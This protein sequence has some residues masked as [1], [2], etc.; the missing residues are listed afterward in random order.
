[1]KTPGKLLLIALLTCLALFK[2]ESLQAGNEK[3]ENV[4]GTPIQN[5]DLISVTD[6]KLAYMIANAGTWQ[7][8]FRNTEVKN[9]VSLYV[10]PACKDYYSNFT[11]SVTADITVYDASGNTKT[12][13]HSFS[14][15]FSASAGNTDTYTD[16]M[17]FEDGHKVEVK[18]TSVSTSLASMPECVK[19]K[20]EI[21]VDRHY[22]LNHTLSGAP[23][24][25][26]ALINS[27][28][29]IEFTWNYVLGAEEYELEWLFI[30]D[31][32][33]DGTYFSTSQL[34]YDFDRQATRVTVPSISYIIPNIYEHGY[35]AYR[36][37]AIGRHT[38]KREWR[39]EGAWWPGT[40]SG[41][42]NTYN[43][44]LQI[45]AAHEADN[46]N[47]SYSANYAEDGKRQEQ[48]N[49]MDG[50]MRNRQSVGRSQSISE[51]IVQETFYDHQGRPGVFTLPAPTGD[52]DL[53]Y[54]DD[55]NLNPSGTEYTAADFDNNDT[56][57]TTGC[58]IHVDGMSTASGAARYYSPNN[59]DK[60]GH[61]AFVPDADSVPFAQI[62]YTNDMSGRL[63]RQSGFGPDH[64]L[65]S[66][67][68]TKYLYGDPSQ[69]FL[70]RMF[71]TDVGLSKH[72]KEITV[73]DPNGQVSSSYLDQKGNI[74][75]TSLGGG[76]HPDMVPLANNPGAVNDT[77]S[78]LDLNEL[79]TNINNEPYI[80]MSRNLVVKAAG[81]Y[82]FVYA[83][84]TQ[85]F[86]DTCLPEGMCLEC[87]YDL[88][89]TIRD[90][91][92]NQMI[93]GG[94]IN[95][96]IGQYPFDVD[97]N[98][99]VRHN[100]GWSIYLN[101]GEYYVDKKLTIKRDIADD[102]VQAYIDSSSC[103]YDYDHFLQLAL[104]TIDFS[105]C[106]HTTSSLSC[107]DSLG[108]LDDFINDG[109]DTATYDSLFAECVGAYYGY[110]NPCDPLLDQ[111]ARDLS[112]G[113]QYALY[114][115]SL[116]A[117]NPIV[118]P[119]SILNENNNL[120]DGNANWRNPHTPYVDGSG[121]LDSIYYNGSYYP[122]G[123]DSISVDLFIANWKP[124]WAYSLVEYHPEY[125]YYDYCLLNAASHAWDNLFD[126]TANFNDALANGYLNP[127][128][129]ST[130]QGKPTSVPSNTTNQ[131]PFFDTGGMGAALYS[132]LQSKLQN[133]ATIGTETYTIW[134]MAQIGT[135]CPGISTSAQ[136][137]SCLL[138]SGNF[139]SDSCN[140][141]MLWALFRDGY[142]G[143]KNYYYDSLMMDF[144]IKNGCYN[145]CIGADST[146]FW[147]EFIYCYDPSS[148]SICLDF[149][150]GYNV[151][152]DSTQPCSDSTAH[153]Y[154]NKL[155]VWGGFHSQGSNLANS[156][157]TAW[158]NAMAYDSSCAYYC[159]SY[160]DAWF[161]AFDMCG[162]S[163]IDSTNLRADLIAIC[164]LGCDP[165]NPYG[166]SSTA[167]DTFF[168]VIGSDT[169]RSFEDLFQYNSTYNA[170]LSDSCSPYMIT[171]P[172]PHGNSML[173]T[174]L[175]TC[176][177]DLILQNEYSWDTASVYPI[178]VTNAET[179]FH[180]INGFY[181]GNYDQLVCKCS[182][183]YN[184]TWS[185]SGS[186][187]S[188]Q[189]NDLAAMQIYVAPGLR[190]TD[191]CATCSEIASFESQFDASITASGYSITDST[192]YYLMLS[193]YIDAST[194]L[195]FS[196]L[197]LMNFT[198]HCD[199]V[200]GTA[201]DTFSLC[202]STFSFPG[203]DSL[204]D[205]Q[206]YLINVANYSAQQ[207]YQTYLD[208]VRTSIY[209][210][211]ISTCIK[212][213]DTEEYLKVGKA[214]E[215]QY[216]LYYYDQS[217]LLVKT[218]P[219]KGVNPLSSSQSGA[220]NTARN[221]SN[222]LRPNHTLVTKYR[223]NTLNGL[224]SQDTPDGGETE[225]WYDD[226]GRLTFSQNAKQET[227]GW[228]SYTLYDDIGR[229]RE[230]GQLVKPAPGFSPENGF[231]K[232][233]GLMRAFF[234]S[235]KR[236][237]ITRT[238]Y[239]QP[240]HD[241]IDAE[242]GPDGQENLHLRIATTAYYDSASC[243]TC[244]KYATHFSYDVHGNVKHM[245]QDIKPLEIID[246]RFK[247]IAYEYDLVSGNVNE[248]HY[249]PEEQDGFHHRYHYDDDNRLAE[250]ETS[251][252]EEVWASDAK[253]FYY[254]HGPV[255]RVERGEHQVQAEDIA[256]TINGW[257]KGTNSN[258]LET[259]LDQGN[260][261]D[262]GYFSYN[263]EIHRW[264]APDEVSYTLGYFNGDFKGIGNG[265]SQNWLSAQT[266]SGLLDASSQLHNGNIGQMITN[267]G[268][269]DAQ[270]MA[271]TYDQLNRL[272][273]ATAFQNMS[274][275]AWAAN[276]ALT[277]YNV[278]I[279]YDQNGNITFLERNGHGGTTDMDD[280]SYH[281]GTTNN[282]LLRVDDDPTFSSNYGVDI[283]D[284]DPNNYGYN[285][286]GQLAVD[287][288]E[289]AL[290]FWNLYGKIRSVGRFG[291]GSESVLSFDYNPQGNRIKKAIKPRVTGQ[292]QRQDDWTESWYV[293]DVRGNIMAIYG[294]EYEE[295]F[296]YP[297]SQ[298]CAYA[299]L[300][301]FPD[302]RET[303]SVDLELNGSSLTGGPLPWMDATIACDVAAAINANTS[304]YTASCSNDTVYICST[305]LSRALNG[306]TLNLGS[307]HSPKITVLHV[308]FSGGAPDSG[309]YNMTLTQDEQHIYG[310]NR[311][312]ISKHGGAESQAQ[313]TS[314]LEPMVA[315]EDWI[316]IPTFI[317]AGDY[318]AIAGEFQND[319]AL[320]ISP[321]HGQATDV[322]IGELLINPTS[323]DTINGFAV[324]GR[325]GL[326]T[327]EYTNH[328]ENVLLT[329]SDRHLPQDQTANDEVDYYAADVL[330]YSDY[331]PYGMAM[332]G[333]NTNLSDYRFGYQGSE[334]DNEHKGDGNSYT[335]FFRQHDPRLGR[336]FSMDP[337]FA[338]FPSKSPFMS[339]SNN[340]IIFIDPLGDTDFYT[341][342]G[343]W[344]GTDGIE[345][346]LRTIVKSS[347]YARM[348]K[349]YTKSGMYFDEPVPA[350]IRYDLP[351]DKVLQEIINVHE[352][353]IAHN[354]E[355]NTEMGSVL[356]EAGEVTQQLIGN[357]PY[358][359]PGQ[360]DA[361]VGVTVK[362][363]VK[364]DKVF[365]HSHPYNIVKD[366][367]NYGATY[368]A[369]SLADQGVFRSF[370]T[371]IIIGRGSEFDK[372]LYVQAGL[373]E[374]RSLV[375]RFYG[376]AVIAKNADAG[377]KAELGIGT[378]RGML[379]DNRGKLGQK[380]DKK[381]KKPKTTSAIRSSNR[382]KARIR[383]RMDK[384]RARSGK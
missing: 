211:Y 15:D 237:E 94:S 322:F 198:A 195:N 64:A 184:A 234:K 154:A 334:M 30:D 59:P 100:E 365:I 118:F 81:Y 304:L 295:V 307:S 52:N 290:Y 8:E 38:D 333:R 132:T 180:H 202:K 119:L 178:S 355:G 213:K 21:L 141:E 165:F 338:A 102:Y 259:D 291:S 160:A 115:D 46:F 326:K 77:T 226:I 361:S 183:A 381:M 34:A 105:G 166:S 16:M 227:Q 133:F 235:N 131:D 122:P 350:D 345:N 97:C 151:S 272:V 155:S 298:S 72:Y 375:V 22:I 362:T 86:R 246:H 93:P 41:T 85:V 253:Y 231:P 109:G 369:P 267:W 83:F 207:A 204:T 330:S 224:I 169:V 88:E 378:I 125:C 358:T 136:A 303:D 23:N 278:N 266:G 233:N 225:Y 199:S 288:S 33:E 335:T 377:K 128:N 285:E 277:D 137:D 221:N 300:S 284:Q 181:V 352:R 32:E 107:L 239:D 82:A 62:E 161:M 143:L 190:C 36:I 254:D 145:G 353:V 379:N 177:C 203:P 114:R 75:M 11:A 342:H 173:G 217:G 17:V 162:L 167:P 274:A 354:S 313:F 374:Y 9:R 6:D 370:E 230:V 359:S 98:D 382:K 344:I 175:D 270:A 18:V 121:A 37:R 56:I 249:Q 314:S 67:H 101:V 363:N 51:S 113:G 194:G 380:M 264:T 289:N 156:L 157:S 222:N 258:M 146:R 140:N 305:E 196:P 57:D 336:W 28:R 371:N 43:Q 201:G 99:S 176:G 299:V 275:N 148:P 111:M 142:M 317:T 244:Y 35:I 54:H 14:V 182:E 316:D 318:F 134:Q 339:N 309:L 329:T 69:D 106:G 58:S 241:N 159:E 76:S 311:L 279:S 323:Q 108:T 294:T 73:I 48:A 70:N 228:Y 297:G 1:M 158:G 170:Y 276:G 149:K 200:S 367:N 71:G 24:V 27:N 68:E 214:H 238:F 139:G 250:A 147:T 328:L 223:Y 257:I 49:Y 47:W 340:P 150:H 219:P 50:V 53:G 90:E 282:Q 120:P 252:Q 80:Q 216:T 325:M 302:T 343:K 283:D 331:Y 346:G 129:N 373:K 269:M 210:R 310:N 26:A 55:F 66:G 242:F 265:S 3:F 209:S 215:Y 179:Y 324:E 29:D 172:M 164:Q 2:V 240:I 89:M 117:I 321:I 116:F 212:A 153:Y 84:E 206:E 296:F 286:I 327:Y 383:K 191:E 192:Y 171:A 348:I 205:C 347:D 384:I 92:G 271:Y 110:S 349:L 20:S 320:T 341:V 248:I 61:Q 135:Y 10:D 174:N 44:K 186:W 364:G 79:D 40:T 308:P 368:A 65:S 13:S 281:Y 255:A 306:D 293:R 123:H 74:I 366:E 144:A 197:Q 292:L 332:V 96:T 263:P 268:Q 112:P 87:T 236:T 189:V 351:S 7:N 78:L 12:V 95:K 39:L 372:E 229:I 60:E 247:H 152:N 19:I 163:T 356:N 243:D 218:V 376:S 193:N 42:L 130:G 104:D 126:G 168:T 315:Y 357:A 256:Y 187:N 127:L 287:T 124:S 337:E 103:L 232:G 25:G 5:G 208:S 301:A 260:D 63:R 280:F 4:S 138:S 319:K 185:P 220:V 91:C 188:T 245:I 262:T 45:N 251:P 360:S 261:A 273:E 31:Y 312:G